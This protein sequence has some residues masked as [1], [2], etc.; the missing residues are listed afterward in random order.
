[1]Q[2]LL[3][4]RRKW[5]NNVSSYWN[6]PFR[7]YE[8][9]ISDLEVK[10]LEGL[11]IHLVSCKVY[12]CDQCQLKFKS[13]LDI[14]E[15]IVEKKYSG[16]YEYVL[17]IYN[18]LSSK[19]LIGNEF[20]NCEYWEA[21]D[22]IDLEMEL[23]IGYWEGTTKRKFLNYILI[24]SNEVYKLKNEFKSLVCMGDLFSWVRILKGLHFENLYV[25]KG[26]ADRPMEHLMQTLGDDGKY[27]KCQKIQETWKFGHGIIILKSFH[28]STSFEASTREAIL[29]DF[30]G[31]RQAYKHKT[32]IILREGGGLEQ[33]KAYQHGFAYRNQV[34]AWLDAA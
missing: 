5:I 27:K 25:G 9:G 22:N 15:Y 11:E 21:A 18:R 29:I 28:H 14:K 1:M 6:I 33:R 20:G 23:S 24:G 16:G 26:Q 12:Q 2:W 17:D 31:G 8:C 10:D 13:I 30:F 7:N 32:R 4:W 19:I 3:F 34:Y